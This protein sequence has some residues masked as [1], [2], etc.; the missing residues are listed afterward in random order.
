MLKI[1]RK[2]VDYSSIFHHPSFFQPFIIH[3][4]IHHSLNHTS[5]THQFIIHS[6]IHHSLTHSL[7]SH[8]F[9]IHLSIHQS[10]IHSYIIL[11]AQTTFIHS[12]SILL[13]IWKTRFTSS[14]ISHHY[15]HGFFI[16]IIILFPLSNSRSDPYI[17][18]DWLPRF[19]KMT[20][21]IS[22]MHIK[23]ILK[24]CFRKI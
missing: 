16:I 1:D 20:I 11:G 2:N 14:F 5:F 7:F 19:N 17:L 23:S 24:I 13:F 8:P 15:H 22:F 4:P 9:I 12:S 10:L 18:S 21:N 6:S 3:S